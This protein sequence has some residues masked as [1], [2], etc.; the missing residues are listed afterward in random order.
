MSRRSI[1]RALA[2]QAMIDA[3]SVKS[4][5]FNVIGVHSFSRF[6]REP[7]ES[8]DTGVS[9]S[10][11]LAILTELLAYSQQQR[12]YKRPQRRFRGSRCA[13]R[14]K[15]GPGDQSQGEDCKDICRDP[16]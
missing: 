11:A 4:P 12:L 5:T 9:R 1:D 16:R 8:I 2:F 7:Q 13:L 14:A 6:F 15:C 10:S 3:A